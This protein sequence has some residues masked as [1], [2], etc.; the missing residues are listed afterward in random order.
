MRNSSTLRRISSALDPAADLL[1]RFHLLALHFDDDIALAQILFPRRAGGI[2]R[3][4]QDAL[5]IAGDLVFAPRLAIQG[6]DRKP[7]CDRRDFALGGGA[8]RALAGLSGVSSASLATVMRML[9]FRLLRSTSMLTVLPMGVSATMR[10][11]ARSSATGLPSKPV[12][13]SPFISPAFA[14]GPARRDTR[15]QRALRRVRPSPSAISLVTCWM[16]TPIQPR[17]A[18]PY[19]R[20]CATTSRAR[21]A[22]IAKPMPTLPPE[23]EKNRRID[24][25]HIALPYRTAGRRNCRD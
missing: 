3:H 15:H 2:D 14:D 13:R 6:P 16:R 10:G 20:S 8:E 9:A 22:G 17:R 12:M 7:Q 25:D 1:G 18:M 21:L 23:G 5:H 11:R 24:P 19:W 4:H